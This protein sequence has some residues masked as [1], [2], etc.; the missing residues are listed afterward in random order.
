MQ[1]ERKHFGHLQ[2]RVNKNQNRKKLVIS[3]TT[4]TVGH[5][6]L[7]LSEINP[8]SKVRVKDGEKCH[9]VNLLPFRRRVGKIVFYPHFW[10]K[11][12]EIAV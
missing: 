10:R 7:K 5:K 11:R 1:K 12:L 6:C 9:N 2:T 8:T 3:L 4:S